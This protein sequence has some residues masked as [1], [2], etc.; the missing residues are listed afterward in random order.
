MHSLYMMDFNAPITCNVENNEMGMCV[1][2]QVNGSFQIS[3]IAPPSGQLSSC[4][5]I[6]QSFLSVAHSSSQNL[7]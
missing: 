6:R 2:F 4:L 5:V 3:I 1:N 7:A